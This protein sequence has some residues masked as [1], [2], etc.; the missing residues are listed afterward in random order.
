MRL[1]NR[2]F[3]VGLFV[4]VFLCAVSVAAAQTIVSPTS[5]SVPAV[6]GTQSI[7]VAT[8]RPDEAWT[9]SPAPA[10][11]TAAGSTAGTP[12]FADGTG[13]DARFAYPNHL[14]A[15]AA[16]NVYVAD[17]GNNRIRKVTPA[18][19]V[20]TFAGSG[21]AGGADG[22][23][24]AA[25][26][27][28]PRGIAIDASGTLYVAE[29]WGHRIRKITPE[30]VVTTAAGNGTAGYVDAQG[31]NARF[32]YP[33][34]I[35]VD[36]D[37]TLYVTEEHNCTV[38]RITPAG[39]V[40][41]LAG[42]GTAGYVDATGTEARF[43]VPFGVAVD[44]A[45]NVYVA[46]SFN[47]RIR[48]VTAAGVVTTV[49]GSGTPG[50]ANGTGTA[51]QFNEP[52]GLAID[53]AGNVYVAE[54]VNH[55]VRRI[56][57]DG[58]VTTL[59][60]SSA[61]YADGTGTVAQF[62]QP[63]GVALTTSGSVLIVSEINGG[64]RIRRVTLGADWITVS[65]A[66]GMGSGSVTLTAEGTSSPFPRTASVMIAG[67]PVVA[68]QDGAAAAIGVLPAVLD[69]GAMLAGAGPV[70]R[71]L[72]VTNAGNVV[73]TGWQWSFGGLGNPVEG[74][75]GSSAA[76][77]GGLYSLTPGQSCTFVLR[78]TPLAAGS[79]GGA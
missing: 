47:H 22:T 77:P 27:N 61:G 28:G 25:S 19:E 57:P 7:V 32:W 8:A 59:A 71:T 79:A 17:W 74:T 29:S 49:A 30:A 1:Q 66:G 54:R 50:S 78:F 33:S 43:N 2:G 34:G 64:N 52:W 60:G 73:L 75:C 72:T 36:G 20:T 6:G 68:T 12:S 42:D 62:T 70:D 3:G 21:A 55:L 41:T 9:A 58:T 46:D 11:T 65:P 4:I 37:G 45:G 63:V 48:K 44:A 39:E 51:A 76:N 18:G 14:A 10:V 69:F 5:W 15:D 23:G 31:T 24:T 38:R 56:G 67:Q 16:G 35:A 26:F 40:T 53:T 13:T